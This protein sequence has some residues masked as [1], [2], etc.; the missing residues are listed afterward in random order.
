R[1]KFDALS[2]EIAEDDAAEVISGAPGQ[3]GSH[4]LTGKEQSRAY[5]EKRTLEL[6][7][8]L[9]ATP[10]ARARDGKSGQTSFMALLDDLPPDDAPK[11]DGGSVNRVTPFRPMAKKRGG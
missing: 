2:R 4:F 6:E 8:E 10:Y 3:T 1:A 5:H 11:G 7:R 9:L